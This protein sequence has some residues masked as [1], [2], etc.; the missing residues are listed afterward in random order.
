M[1]KADKSIVE[2]IR[3]DQRQLSAGD[4]HALGEPLIAVEPLGCFQQCC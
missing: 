1:L 3:W 4:M 2:E